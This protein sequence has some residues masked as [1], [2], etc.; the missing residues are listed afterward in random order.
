M[1]GG[2]LAPHCPKWAKFRRPRRISIPPHAEILVYIYIPWY[3]TVTVLDR[4]EREIRDLRKV[5]ITAHVLASRA[6]IAVHDS[7]FYVSEILELTLSYFEKLVD[8]IS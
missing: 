7:E 3:K 6:E 5:I 2:D 1:N 4:R 8:N